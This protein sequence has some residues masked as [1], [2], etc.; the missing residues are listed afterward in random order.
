MTL[1]M[2]ISSLLNKEMINPSPLYPPPN[3][4]DSSALL[5]TPGVDKLFYRR[6]YTWFSRGRQQICSF[7]V[8]KEIDK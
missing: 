6:L 3:R 8:N 2:F 7:L 5:K 4:I 1:G